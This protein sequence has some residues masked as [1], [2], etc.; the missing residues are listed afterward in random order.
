MK[1]MTF[2]AE[3]ESN[4]DDKYTSN[5]QC[6]IYQPSGFKPHALTLLDDSRAKRL[7]EEINSADISEDD[8]QFLIKAASR[9]IV[10]NYE[11]IANYYAHSDK[12]VQRLMEN[13][14]LVII[15]F[16]RAVELGFIEICDKL[17]KEFFE[18]YSDQLEE[19]KK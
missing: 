19:Q 6:P 17:K 5:V 3:D 9:H 16:E 15:D 2:F 1:Q 18:E 7:I 4:K 14:A 12:T 13:S 10:F 8:K 11:L